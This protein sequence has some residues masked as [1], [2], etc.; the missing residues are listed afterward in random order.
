MRF[1]SA[2]A[3]PACAP[4][5]AQILT[6]RYPFRTG[7]IDNAGPLSPRLLRPTEPTFAR[8]LR[9]AGYATVMAG[10][11]QLGSLAE[12]SNMPQDSGFTKSYL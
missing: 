8:T 6:G 10:K 9:D 4:S 7:W 3:T 11:W 5:R 2:F 1:T 12:Y